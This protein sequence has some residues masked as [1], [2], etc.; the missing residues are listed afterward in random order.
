MGFQIKDAKGEPIGINKI[1]EE[2]AQFWGVEVEKKSYASPIVVTPLPDG[3]NRDDDAGELNK[4]HFDQLTRKITCNWFDQIGLIIDGGADTW[5]EVKRRYLEP[6]QGI[7]EK[8][9]DKPN[10]EEIRKMVMDTPP[11]KP[12]ADL[13]EYWRGKGY[14]PHPVHD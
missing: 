4:K 9:K 3:Y 7:V 5:D 2:V 1:D 14:T 11:V 6:Y 13:I 10:A 12:F 8:Y